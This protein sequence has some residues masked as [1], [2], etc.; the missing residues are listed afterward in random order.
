MFARIRAPDKILF[1]SPIKEHDHS[2]VVAVVYSPI[3][4][5]KLKK[6]VVVKLRVLLSELIFVSQKFST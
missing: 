5:F 1:P 2:V 6:R 4:G 3:F